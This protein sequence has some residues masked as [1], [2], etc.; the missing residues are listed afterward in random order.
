M[1]VYSQEK[2]L[3]IYLNSLTLCTVPFFHFAILLPLLTFL[4]PVILFPPLI[5]SN[6]PFLYRDFVI[7]CISKP[8]PKRSAFPFTSNFVLYSYLGLWVLV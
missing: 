1:N 4:S 5:N 6:N 2:K 8:K 7:I 3:L